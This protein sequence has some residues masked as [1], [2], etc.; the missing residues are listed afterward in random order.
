MGTDEAEK[1][2]DAWKDGSCHASEKV[3][4]LVS[5]DNVH[6]FV[7]IFVLQCHSRVL[8]EAFTIPQAPPAPRTNVSVSNDLAEPPAKI[9]LTDSL[10]E[11]SASLSF[12]LALAKGECAP[13]IALE[14]KEYKGRMV[15]TLHGAILLARKWDCPMILRELAKALCYYG[16]RHYNE[17]EI[18]PLDVFIL[19]GQGSTSGEYSMFWD[20]AGH[21]IRCYEPPSHYEIQKGTEGAS[22]PVVDYWGLVDFPDVESKRFSSSLL[23]ATAC[24]HIGPLF[25][26]ALAGTLDKEGARTDKGDQLDIFGERLCQFVRT[27]VE[28]QKARADGA[29]EAVDEY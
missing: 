28:L 16:L 5:S 1:V 17:A 6:F 4:H 23:N 19:A 18:K 2:H 14:T 26:F 25:T 20:A 8:R 29:K 22:F 21:V 7:P 10:C 13:E 27:Q 24:R 15:Q 11:S 9:E 12:F 3:V